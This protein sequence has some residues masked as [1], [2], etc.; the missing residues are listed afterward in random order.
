ML[1]A[2][3]AFEFISHITIFLSKRV[4]MI[5]SNN[6]DLSIDRSNTDGIIKLVATRHVI[7]FTKPNLS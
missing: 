6:F 4:N 5:F 1:K 3:F 2:A 7:I